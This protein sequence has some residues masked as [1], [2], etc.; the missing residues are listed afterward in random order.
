ML[1]LAGGGFSP[2]EAMAAASF[3]W[4]IDNSTPGQE[5]LL[6]GGQAYA[7]VLSLHLREPGTQAFWWRAGFHVC[8]LTGVVLVLLLVVCEP[9]AFGLTGSQ[10]KCKHI[11]FKFWKRTF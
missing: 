2:S 9:P 10:S 1:V 8:A 3:P 11:Q 7:F 5:E 6:P 4:L